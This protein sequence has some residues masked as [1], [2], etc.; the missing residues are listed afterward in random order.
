MMKLRHDQSGLRPI[1]DKHKPWLVITGAGVSLYSGIPT[2]R[3]DNGDWLRSDPIKHHEFIQYEDKRKHYWARSAVGWPPVERALPN[4]AHYALAELERRGYFAGLITQNV[5]RLHQ[6]AGQQHVIDLHGRLDRVRCLQ[7]GQF[8]DR[9]QLQIRL[10][11]F[12]S[13]LA[14]LTATLA[15]DG[16]AHVRDEITRRMKLVNCL[17]CDGILMPDVVFFGGAISKQTHLAAARLYE[18]CNGVLTIGSSLMVYSGFRYCKLAKQDGKPLM[19][20]NRGRTRADDIVDHK[21]GQDCQTVLTA[22][23][24]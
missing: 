16:D 13:F 6:R 8:E 5:D 18:Q 19:I 10:L 17:A 15:P 1:L 7:C 23:V 2:Y 20:I 11:E 4:D 24:A 3:D 14:P 22:L 9:Q 12:N 21:I